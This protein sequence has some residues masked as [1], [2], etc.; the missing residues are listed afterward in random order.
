[1]TKDWI[2]QAVGDGER[3]GVGDGIGDTDGIR[4]GLGEA[5]ATLRGVT[6]GVAVE[7]AVIV[8]EEGLHAIAATRSSRA[9]NRRIL[10]T[11]DSRQE[12][13]LRRN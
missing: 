12:K 13:R 5:V 9:P 3:V 10:F 1:M 11:S 6:V 8:W 7:P 2:L 4:D